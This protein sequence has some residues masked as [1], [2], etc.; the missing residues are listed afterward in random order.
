MELHAAGEI[1]KYLCQVVKTSAGSGNTVISG[2]QDEVTNITGRTEDS[3]T[4]EGAP[5]F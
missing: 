3:V 4:V 2:V 5:P 1:N